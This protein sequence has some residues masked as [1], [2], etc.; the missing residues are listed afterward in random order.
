MHPGQPQ[1]VS[2]LAG[3]HQVIASLA[4]TL[5]RQLL[6]QEPREGHGARGRPSG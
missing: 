2:V 1:M 4:L 3:E 5:P 6:T